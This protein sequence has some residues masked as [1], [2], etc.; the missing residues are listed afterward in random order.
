VPHTF[1][2]PL[3]AETLYAEVAGKVFYFLE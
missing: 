3:L 2:A 1:E